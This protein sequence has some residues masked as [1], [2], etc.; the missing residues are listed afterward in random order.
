MYDTKI[1][2]DEGSREASQERKIRHSTS[3]KSSMWT[4]AQLDEYKGY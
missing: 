4:H 3:N 1:M 2:W